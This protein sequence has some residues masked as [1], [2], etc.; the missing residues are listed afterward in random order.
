MKRIIFALLFIGCGGG[1]GSSGGYS[2]FAGTWIANLR[3]TRNTC[4]VP[5][6]TG[7]DTAYIVN[8][9]GQNI[10]IENLATGWTANGIAR[11]DNASFVAAKNSP[12]G[13]CRFGESTIALAFTRDDD[14]VAFVDF[15]SEIRCGGAVFCEV[16]AEGHA[17]RI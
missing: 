8:Q 13:D 5:I 3:V 6:N 1:G 16:Q 9:D 2:S 7:G 4:N 12:I 11:E 17:G 14:D 15:V 10:A